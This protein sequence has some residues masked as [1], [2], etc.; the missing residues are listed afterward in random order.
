MS[1]GLLTLTDLIESV[2]YIRYWRI[3]NPVVVCAI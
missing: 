2:V 1:S 3:T